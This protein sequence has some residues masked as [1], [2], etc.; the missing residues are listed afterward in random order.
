MSD[1]PAPDLRGMGRPDDQQVILG[2]APIIGST[3]QGRS[4]SGCRQGVGIQ[5]DTDPVPLLAGTGTVRRKR[6]SEC[7]EEVELAH[8]GSLALPSSKYLTD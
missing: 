4:I 8:L 3:S 1:V 6:L 2:E 7:I 5:V